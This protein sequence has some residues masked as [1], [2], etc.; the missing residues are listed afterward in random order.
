[1][2]VE[3]PKPQKIIVDMSHAWTEEDKKKNPEQWAEIERKKQ[4][5]GN[6]KKENK[7][8]FASAAEYIKSR[9]DCLKGNA[10]D[11][12][13]LQEWKETELDLEYGNNLK[14]MRNLEICASAEHLDKKN[15]NLWRKA[16]FEINKESQHSSY[17]LDKDTVG[18]NLHDE[19]RKLQDKINE[20]LEKN[21]SD[22][23]EKDI[24]HWDKENLQWQDAANEVFGGNT[25]NALALLE[26]SIEER[27][28]DDY[29][30]RLDIETAAKSGKSSVEYITKTKESIDANSES[31][32][33]LR[34]MRDSLYAIEF[35][36]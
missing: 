25:E 30:L 5:N 3:K 31:L 11:D 19:F 27:A 22:Y 36:K 8:K 14:A 10:K 26:K 20:E 32:A 16:I 21:P 33:T 6:E 35:N 4:E 34:R 24:K 1:M 2:D 18:K 28:R 9:I 29:S 17:F 23:N 12:E 7:P 15:I 13:F